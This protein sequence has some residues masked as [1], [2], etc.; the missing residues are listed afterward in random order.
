VTSYPCVTGA[1][2]LHGKEDETHS[3]AV[4]WSFAVIS[5]HPAGAASPGLARVNHALYGVK[6]APDRRT[7]VAAESSRRVVASSNFTQRV[8]RVQPRRGTPL[9]ASGDTS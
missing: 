6:R 5:A 9:P 3:P 7:G 2:A 1:P 4:S 8:Q